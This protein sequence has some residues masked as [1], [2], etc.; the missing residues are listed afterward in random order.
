MEVNLISPMT[1]H[2]RPRWLVDFSNKH[3]LVSYSE[4]K[5]RNNFNLDYIEATH[6]NKANDVS[7]LYALNIE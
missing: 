2:V 1:P 3:L 6:L 4:S 7:S 5:Q